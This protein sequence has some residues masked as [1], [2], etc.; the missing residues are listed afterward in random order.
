MNRTKQLTM[1]S[2]FQLIFGH[3]LNFFTSLLYVNNSLQSGDDQKVDRLDKRVEILHQNENF[4]IVNKP[5]DLLINGGDADVNDTLH[6]RLENQFPA[7]ICRELKYSFYFPHRLDYST[8]GLIAIALN[9]EA[10]NLMRQ[11][12][13]KRCV[14]K[15]YLALV[16][17]IVSQ[18]SLDVHD[19]IGYNLKEIGKSNAMCSPEFNPNC[20]HPRSAHTKFH[21]LSYGEYDSYPCTKLL[22]RIITGRRHQIR[23]H[24]SNLGHTIVGDYTYSGRKDVHP[25]RQMLHAYRLRV[26][27][28]LDFDFRTRDPFAET[29]P[30][31]K[32]DRVVADLND[33]RVYDEIDQL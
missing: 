15:Y 33:E 4:L 25:P 17:G 12:F 16:R 24:C 6:T 3:V 30:Q 11:Y 27:Q 31:W 28:S 20:I 10:C 8:S 7:L 2:F 23:V 14:R 22:I 21:V 1:L 26:G 29:L 13:E 9:K 5:P 18:T 19:P 32:E